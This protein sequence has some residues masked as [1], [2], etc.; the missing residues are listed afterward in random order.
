MISKGDDG[1]EANE[2]FVSQVS[3]DSGSNSKTG[4]ITSAFPKPFPG[5]KGEG[6]GIHCSDIRYSKQV[7]EG[8]QQVNKTVHGERQVGQRT[9]SRACTARKQNNTNPRQC[10]GPAIKI[11]QG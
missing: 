9:G 5:H 1:T 3:K 10:A 2:P 11:A 7:D 8:Q 6:T 4:G